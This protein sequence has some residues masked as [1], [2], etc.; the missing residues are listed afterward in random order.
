MT[1]CLRPEVLFLGFRLSTALITA[2]V[3]SG[4]TLF[5]SIRKSPLTVAVHR[6]SPS[7]LILFL[8]SYVT[9]LLTSAA[10]EPFVL[11]PAPFKV[12]IEVSIQTDALTFSGCTVTVVVTLL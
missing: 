9:Q 8:I 7:P 6:T 10:L 2:T 5:T 1:L 3:T 4:A 11:V 12:L